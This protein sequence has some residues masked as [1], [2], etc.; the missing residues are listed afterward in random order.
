[1]RFSY[2]EREVELLCIISND[3]MNFSIKN[4]IK[5][6]LKSLKKSVKI[7]NKIKI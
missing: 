3:Y 4:K 2:K 5:I 6:L 1:M 7:Y